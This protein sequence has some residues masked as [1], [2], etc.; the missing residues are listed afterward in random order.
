[1]LSRKNSDVKIPGHKLRSANSEY[2]FKSDKEK[3]NQNNLRQ[4]HS[5]GDALNTRSLPKKTSFSIST[6]YLN[7]KDVFYLGSG[8]LAWLIL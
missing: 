4:M 1:M 7:I 5:I 8:L 3:L 6:G 2:F